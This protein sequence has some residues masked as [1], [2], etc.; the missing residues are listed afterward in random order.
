M[1]FSEVPSWCGEDHTG[2]L[3]PKEG[4]NGLKGEGICGFSLES[5]HRIH[6]MDLPEVMVL[7]QSSLEKCDSCRLRELIRDRDKTVKQPEFLLEVA[8]ELSD[9]PLPAVIE[10]EVGY[11]SGQGDNVM[12]C[13][14]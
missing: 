10:G 7:L 13:N 5:P 1:P 8:E 3:H 6:D 11:V 14:I 9:C 2:E 4:C 12:L